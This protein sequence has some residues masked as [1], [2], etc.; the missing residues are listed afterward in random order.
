IEVTQ[1]EGNRI[2][3][4]PISASPVV[5]AARKYNQLPETIL[6]SREPPADSPRISPDTEVDP[7]DDPLA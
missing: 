4:R 2:T 1:V 6:D 5:E 3:V 7:F